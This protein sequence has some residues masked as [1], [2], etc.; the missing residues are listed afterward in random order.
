V[1][2]IEL[3]LY[4]LYAFRRKGR[5]AP[6]D[7]LGNGFREGAQQLTLAIWESPRTRRQLLWNCFPRPCIGLKWRCYAT[8][9]EAEAQPDPSHNG[10]I[11]KQKKR[12]ARADAPKSGFTLSKVKTALF[13]VSTAAGVVVR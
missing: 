2:E 7:A 6:E 4:W 13:D 8:K 1:H 12:G 11:K 5:S 10:S 9:V 3:R